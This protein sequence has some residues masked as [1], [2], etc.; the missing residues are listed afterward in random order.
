MFFGVIISLIFFNSNLFLNPHMKKNTKKLSLIILAIILTTAVIFLGIDNFFDKN[1]VPNSTKNKISSSTSITQ[2]NQESKTSKS[3][4][5]EAAELLKISQNDI[6]LGDKN[7]PVLVVEY[8]S[9]SCPHCASFYKDGFEQFKKE[10][11]DTGKA[12]LIYRDFPLNKP[13][14]D[15]SLLALCQT[16]NKSKDSTQYYN[17]IKA[18]FLT[19]E[20]WAFTEEFSSKLETIAKLDGINN[21]EFKKCMQNE[22]LQNQILGHRLKASQVLKISST[23]TF[24]INGEMLN[25]YGGYGDIK[26]AIEEKLGQINSN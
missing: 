11:I 5:N 6:V 10:Y 19:Q 17:F 7:A 12:A 24:F 22:K 25:G 9:L 2:N 20:S 13:A 14:F 15:A 23:P 21:E 26:R 16:Q 18:L 4:N 1:K 8:A 3:A